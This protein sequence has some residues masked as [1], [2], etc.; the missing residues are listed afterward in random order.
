VSLTVVTP[1]CLTIQVA[2]Q[3]ETRSYDALGF[4]NRKRPLAP[5]EQEAFGARYAW[6]DCWEHLLRLAA[7]DGDITIADWGRG[8]ARNTVAGWRREITAQLR[9]ALGLREGEFMYYS[10]KEGCYRT[11]AR[12]TMAAACRK[13]MR[14]ELGGHR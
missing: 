12:L 14:A 7:A 13:A 11:N 1:Y 8:A 5:A 10:R 3:T 9:E 4:A 6:N 2:G